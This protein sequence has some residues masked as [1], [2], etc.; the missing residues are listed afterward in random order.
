MNDFDIEALANPS[1]LSASDLFYVHLEERLA[2]ATLG[3]TT[4]EGNEGFE[5]FLV[6]TGVRQVTV[7]GWGP[8]GSKR[9]DLVRS[10]DGIAVAVQD[11]NSLLSFRATEMTLARTRTFQAS[12][13]AI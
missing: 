7:R 9:I 10:A 5:F 8:P 12:P 11:E 4:Q 13:Q 2:S 3:F 6:F 1:M